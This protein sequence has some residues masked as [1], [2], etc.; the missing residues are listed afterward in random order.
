MIWKTE[1][2]VGDGMK[3]DFKAAGC[4]DGSWLQLS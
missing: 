4:E 1:K 3:M 2:A